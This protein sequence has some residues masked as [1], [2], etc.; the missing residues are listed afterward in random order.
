VRAAF[1]ALVALAGCAVG[2][3]SRPTVEANACY[4]SGPAVAGALEAV[5][6]ERVPAQCWA[7]L[8]QYEVSYVSAEE[9]PCTST[10]GRVIGC[11]FQPAVAT[12]IL[13]LEGVP[14][15]ELVDISAHEWLHVLAGCA[16]GDSDGDHG[17]PELW[18]E[19]LDAVLG[20]ALATAP[21]GPCLEGA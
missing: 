5:Y 6:G 7:L 4:A 15:D 16:L 17:D 20:L 12:R 8:E 2:E 9:M 19:G 3:A 11:S 21:M 18:G 1:L 14:N 13:L 10:V